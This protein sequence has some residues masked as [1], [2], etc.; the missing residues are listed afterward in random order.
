MLRNALVPCKDLLGTQN[1]LK[2][3]SGSFGN[4]QL[5]KQHQ[6]TSP[7]TQSDS[8]QNQSSVRPY[9]PFQVSRSNLAE[10][11]LARLDDL[12]NWGRKSSMWPLSFGLACCAVEMMHIA[13]PRY[14]MDRYFVVQA[15]HCKKY[16][17]L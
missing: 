6:S 4:V 1:L 5:Q 16:C 9:S 11:A 7:K 17:L 13:A 8:Q 15:L 12:L 10:Y 14:D 2:T 3:V